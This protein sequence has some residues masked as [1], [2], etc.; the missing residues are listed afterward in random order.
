MYLVLLLIG[1]LVTAAGFV[2]I[3][4]GIPINA[5]NLGSFGNTLFIAGATLLTGGLVLVGL[6]VVVRQLQRVAA[7]LAMQPATQPA[8]QGEAP[9]PLVPPTARM[10][11]S[12]MASSS[13][14]PPEAAPS[15]PPEPRGSEP[16]RLEPRAS[17]SR[18]PEPRASEPRTP[19]PQWPIS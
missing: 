17:E 4:F 15:R 2:A 1:L 5:L 16:R 10:S 9:E 6:A 19:A 8:R 14:R 13:V 12:P 7:G 3:G 11:L 18:Q